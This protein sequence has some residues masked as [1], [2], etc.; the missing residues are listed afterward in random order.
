MMMSKKW[1]TAVLTVLTTA[2]FCFLLLPGV[3]YAADIHVTGDGS[4]AAQALNNGFD[5]GAK[6]ILDKDVTLTSGQDLVVP[7]GKNA[8]L[9]LA[10]HTLTLDGAKLTVDGELKFENGGTVV[11]K[12]SGKLTAVP[13]KLDIGQTVVKEVGGGEIWYKVATSSNATKVEAQPKDIIS[14][15]F[16]GEQKTVDVGSTLDLKPQFKPTVL[17]NYSVDVMNLIWSSDDASIALVDLKNGVVTGKKSGSATITVRFADFPTIATSVE[18]TVTD[19]TVTSVTLSE[20]QFNLKKGDK[21][22]LTATVQAGADATADQKKVTWKSDNTAVATVDSEGRVSGVSQG[23]A[24]ITASVGSGANVRTDTCKVI[25]YE[26]VIG[27]VEMTPIL[28]TTYDNQT[29]RVTVKMP[30]DI[31]SE[32]SSQTRINVNVVLPAAGIA[33]VIAQSPAKEIKVEVYI[34]K[35]VDEKS[36]VNIVSVKAGEEIF[37][38]LKELNKNITIEVCK[39]NGGALISGWSFTGSQLSKTSEMNLHTE[40]LKIS[41]FAAIKRLAGSTKSS[42]FRVAQ[43]GAFPGKAKITTSLDS[44]IFSKGNSAY[45]YF[46]N[47]SRNR[48]DYMGSLTKVDSNLCTSMTLSKGGDYVITR[49]RLSGSSHDDDDDDDDYYEKETGRWIQNN[50]GWWYRNSNGSYPANKWQQISGKWYLFDQSGYMMTGWQ[51]RNGVWYYLQPSGEMVENNWVL[52]NGRWYFLKDGGAMATGWQQW[53]N[54]W[55]YLSSPNGEMVVRDWLYINDRWFYVGDDGAMFANQWL[56][57]KDKWFVFQAD[58]TMVYGWFKWKDK[59]YYMNYPYG[60]MAVNTTIGGYRV[61][62]DGVMY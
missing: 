57:Y 23:V 36:N 10:G 1:T 5:S 38:K 26:T 28:N 52:S 50:V 59:W 7:D 19:R 18:V 54:K 20:H 60:D 62:S 14:S 12:G 9:D 17:N 55:Y 43:D 31:Y 27:T 35:E 15:A 24:Q 37:K 30:Y 46:Y 51:Y 40:I 16:I 33:N 53:K 8:V 47:E 39:E 11:I 61:G 56:Y 22:Q 58:G 49:S 41:D 29:G 34:S 44:S 25:V 45:L 6:M 3:A 2:L 42:V 13:G 4:Q 32:F 48:L 21:K